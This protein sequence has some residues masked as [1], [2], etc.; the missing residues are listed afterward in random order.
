MGRIAPVMPMRKL[1]VVG[2]EFGHDRQPG[3][4][5]Q[6]PIQPLKL[7]AWMVKVL[8]SLCTSNEV[9]RA[10]NR[11]RGG[12]EYRVVQVHL[13]SSCGQDVREHRNR[14]ASE[15]QTNLR[16]RQS[17]QKGI[18][19]LAKKLTVGGVI[20]RIAVPHVALALVS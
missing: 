8:D 7:L 4:W 11:G 20:H 19:D 6:E 18:R 3:T 13:V 9:V 16:R 10:L 1:L 17:P 14:P 5:T 12:G 15:I 2:L